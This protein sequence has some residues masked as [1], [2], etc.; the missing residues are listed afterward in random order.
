MAELPLINGGSGCNGARQ[1][2]FD[3][4]YSMTNGKSTRSA[5]LFGVVGYRHRRGCA[6]TWQ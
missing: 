5:R 1:N 2:S 4:E 6:K 3:E